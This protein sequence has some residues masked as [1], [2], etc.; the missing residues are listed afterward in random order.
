MNN[1]VRMSLFELQEVIRM[2]QQCGRLSEEPVVYARSGPGNYIP[3]YK[4]DGSLISIGYKVLSIPKDS[5]TEGSWSYYDNYMI[6][7][8]K[9]DFNKIIFGD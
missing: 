4:K 1:T 2:S 9:E 7:V 5:E 3:V 6:E 8:D